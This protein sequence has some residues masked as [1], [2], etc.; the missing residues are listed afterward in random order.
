MG[1]N[2]A[3]RKS[4]TPSFPTATIPVLDPQT[5]SGQ[6]LGRFQ[7]CGARPKQQGHNQK[8]GCRCAQF[9][10]Y[11]GALLL[12]HGFLGQPVS[13]KF[14]APKT[15]DSARVRVFGLQDGDLE[16]IFSRATPQNERMGKLGRAQID[17]ELERTLLLADPLVWFHERWGAA[18]C[19]PGL[20]S[21]F[22]CVFIAGIFGHIP[23]DSQ[24]QSWCQRGCTSSCDC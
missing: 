16:L 8:P 20:S 6:V 11:I 17:K 24:S 12:H 4:T 2:V 1:W 15:M 3:F 9:Q 22:V 7:G 14:G 5:G 13:T 18:T 23:L 10:S 19:C 21:R